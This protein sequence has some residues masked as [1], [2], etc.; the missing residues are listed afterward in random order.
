MTT[1]ITGEILSKVD[2]STSSRQHKEYKEINEES[3]SV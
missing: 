3:Y 2:G 1:Y